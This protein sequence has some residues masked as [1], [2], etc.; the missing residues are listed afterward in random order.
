MDRGAWILYAFIVAC[1]TALSLLHYRTREPRGPGREVLALLRAAA[2]ALLT[3]LLFDPAIAAGA[4][5]RG[6][7]VAL[8]DGSLS[9][10]LPAGPGTRWSEAVAVADSMG[11]DRVLLFG[12]DVRLAARDLPVAA[13]GDSA[14]RLAPAVRG[15]VEAGASQVLVITDG[16][17]EDAAEARQIAEDAGAAL[18]FRQVGGDT[19]GNLG[20]TDV[21]A[22]GWLRAGERGTVQVRVAAVGRPLPD[23]VTV[24]L[25]RAGNE[26]ARATVR[27]PAPGRG[28]TVTLPFTAPSDG[29]SAPVRLDVALEGG[30][31]MAADDRRPVYVRVSEEPA[32]VVLVS[33]RPGEEPRFL[34]PVLQQALG[35]PVRGWLALRGGRYIRLGVGREAG[36]VDDEATVRRALGSADMIVLDGMTMDAPA[37][38]RA[39]A[40]AA[41]RLLL[42]P[43]G[44]LTIAG[45]ALRGA[46]PG[47]W[48]PADSVPPSPV[49]GLLAGVAAADAPPL[50]VVYP[51]S[52]PRGF[53]APLAARESRRGDAR[54]VL[55]AGLTDDGRRVAV[56]LGDG[57]WR[58]A[59]D[60]GT[61][62]A[63]YQR[64]WAG[65]G[66]WMMEGA[67]PQAGDEVRPEPRAVPRSA[68]VRWRVPAAADSLRLVIERRDTAGADAVGP[69]PGAAPADS[70][71]AGM[72]VDTVVPVS[73]GLA[74]S[75]PLPPGE[76][77]Y[78]AEVRLSAG[79]GA[80]A[81][82]AGGG[83]AVRAGAAAAVARGSGE[84]AVESYAPELTR[85]SV[86]AAE[87][88][89]EPGGRA[90]EQGGAASGRP[91][92][93]SPWP[94]VAL[95]LL[96]SVEWVLRRRWGLR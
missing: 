59:F 19:R 67:G 3:L 49:A 21:T 37:W 36:A 22:P 2:L 60:E 66:A 30:G 9:M 87:L 39:Q 50:P 86:A 83:A 89:A 94:Y 5:R 40:D 32:G 18:E 96:L 28:A 54:P 35:V 38:V 71:A 79:E 45:V 12:A 84:L 78:R 16:G 93:A 62:R 76:Y 20:V 26:L 17:I 47:D 65:I 56:A 7:K 74:M 81:E 31:S 42:F 11:A 82:P 57:Y 1:I 6:G 77:V 34:M 53:W 64:L 41:N 55:I 44:P 24:R 72:R 91:L 80:G 70:G 48:Y 8:L 61:A 73:A 92:H 14:T 4:G 13:P 46:V 69:G 43:A 29:G 52:A 25:L 63:L 51:A 23:S 68:T 90:G 58:W 10:S 33:L 88:S 27:A 95:V 85:A 15:A 75:A